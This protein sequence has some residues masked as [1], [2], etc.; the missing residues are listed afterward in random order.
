M[1]EYMYTYQEPMEVSDLL[2]SLS[3]LMQEYTQKMGCRPFGCSILLGDG[4]DE[5]K[6]YQLDPSGVVTQLDER[7]ILHLGRGDGTH[8]KRR[9][10]EAKVEECTNVQDAWDTV[11]KIL[12]EEI[13][14][15]EG[16]ETRGSSLSVLGASLIPG[17]TCQMMKESL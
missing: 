15:K 4:R 17:E 3:A 6:V 1:V 16:R 9:L 8:W 14:E 12:K 7:N 5:S 13:N 11:V 10:E 2:Q